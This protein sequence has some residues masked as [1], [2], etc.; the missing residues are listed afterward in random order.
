MRASAFTDAMAKLEGK[1]LTVWD[2]EKQ[3]FSRELS[4]NESEELA[5]HFGDHRKG[6]W[7]GYYA[8]SPSGPG[9]VIEFRGEDELGV[10]RFGGTGGGPEG[11]GAVL[12]FLNKII[13]REHFPAT[14]KDQSSGAK[15]YETREEWEGNK[16]AELL[17]R[18]EAFEKAFAAQL[19]LEVNHGGRRGATDQKK[20]SIPTPRA[21][22]PS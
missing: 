3:V 21:P 13:G 17:V 16:Q 8:S 5:G 4:E 10:I 2:G 20:I 18:G 7:S 9:Y 1:K 19:Q 22:E 12:G 14:L 11:F 6:K 15:W